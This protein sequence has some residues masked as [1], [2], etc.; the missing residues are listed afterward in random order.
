MIPTATHT[1]SLTHHLRKSSNNLTH[2]IFTIDPKWHPIR[3]IYFMLHQIEWLRDHILHSP[4]QFLLRRSLPRDHSSFIF[5][6]PKPTSSKQ[7]PPWSLIQEDNWTHNW[8]LFYSAS[9]T[10]VPH[11]LF[12]DI[13]LC[14]SH[15]ATGFKLLKDK[16]CT[17]LTCV[18]PITST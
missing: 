17:S 1:N 12:Y 7:N 18:C 15:R 5:P 13:N 6:C 3:H 2:Y 14:T 16:N 10:A 8:I 11:S 9:L 4:P